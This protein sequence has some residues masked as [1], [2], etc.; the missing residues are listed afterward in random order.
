MSAGTPD[1][2]TAG[3]RLRLE[4]LNGTWF[5]LVQYDVF[6]GVCLRHEYLL[7]GQRKTIRIDLPPQA[8]LELA[9]NDIQTNWQSYETKFASEKA[10]D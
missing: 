1:D 10:S 2:L 9:R 3:L 5:P 6:A 8:A 7:D 4:V